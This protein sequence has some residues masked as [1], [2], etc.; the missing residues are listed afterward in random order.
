MIWSL[1]IYRTVEE[2]LSFLIRT[3]I[4]NRSLLALGISELP[5]ET[6]DRVLAQKYSKNYKDAY[7]GIPLIYFFL[8]ILAITLLINNNFMLLM[9]NFLGNGVINFN[10]FEGRSVFFLC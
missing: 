8:E 5:Q 10:S 9:N 3:G 4:L 1:I 2:V 6:I 7:Y